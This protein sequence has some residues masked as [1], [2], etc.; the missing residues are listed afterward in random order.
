MNIVESYTFTPGGPGQ[1]TI[2]IPLE[3]EL[4]DF[5]VITNVTRGVILYNPTDGYTGASLNVAEG[6]STLTLEQSTTFCSAEDDLQIIVYVSGASES[7]LTEISSKLPELVDGK[8]PVDIG[9]NINVSVEN[10]SIEVSNTV[11]EPVPVAS[12][13]VIDSGNGFSGS[14]SGDQTFHGAGIEVSPKYGTISVCI[15]SSHAS[16]TNGLKFQASIDNVNWETIE[17]YSYLS[18]SGLQSYSFAP[19]GRYFRLIYTNGSTATTKTVIFVALRTG[20]TKSSS[21]RIGDTITG[22][23]DAE[24][25]KAVLS[26][27]KPNGDFTDIHCTAGGNLKVSV[28]ETE[29]SLPV[30]GSVSTSV[31]LRSPTTTSVQSSTDSVLILAANANRKGISISNVS[32]SKLYLSFTSPATLSNCFI[33]VQPSQFILFDQQL[34]TG[35]AIYGLWA[36]ANGSCQVTE[37]I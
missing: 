3:L 19:S 6:V 35:N 8:V 13:G 11:D 26:A 2:S 4:E 18:G 1:G 27:M 21:H 10:T 37:F 14:L 5:G 24:L 32:T 20:Y 17:Q 7:T 31:S 25:V 33:E 23:K 29:G 28:E 12:V 22:E 36:S 15:F 16:A 34:L 9:T 30:T